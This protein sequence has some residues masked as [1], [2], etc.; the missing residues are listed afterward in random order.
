LLTNQLYNL[1][2]ITLNTFECLKLNKTEITSLYRQV[3]II[4]YQV[5]STTWSRDLYIMTFIIIT[6][7]LLTYNVIV[8]I[9]WSIN[10]GI[11]WPITISY[12]C[13]NTEVL[14][15]IFYLT[16]W[17]WFGSYGF[18]ASENIQLSNFK[19]QVH[20]GNASFILR[21]MSTEP[22]LLFVCLSSCSNI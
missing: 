6:V 2:I 3:Q 18:W 19:Y 5:N 21:F 4:T 22:Y 10:N 13:I 14:H 17:I 15:V 9:T 20:K 1:F 7:T 11:Y 8:M 16:I 12:I